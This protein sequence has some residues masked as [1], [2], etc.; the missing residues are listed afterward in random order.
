MLQYPPFGS[1][2]A[3]MGSEDSHSH[4]GGP[5]AFLRPAL[6]MLISSQKHLHK[7]TQKEYLIINLGTEWSSQTN[8]SNYHGSREQSPILPQL[9]VKGR[10]LRSSS[11]EQALRKELC[12]S[13]LWRKYSQGKPPRELGV[14][15]GSRTG[16]RRK[17]TKGLEVAQWVGLGLILQESSGVLAF[18]LS[19]TEL[20]GLGIHIPL[21]DSLLVNNLPWEINSLALK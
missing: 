9:F 6:Q 17:R 15:G 12:A 1:V 2:Q 18:S 21:L 19:Q 4:W 7:H 5:S 10:F 3:L 20:R 11:K 14:G 8:T 16:K 13:D